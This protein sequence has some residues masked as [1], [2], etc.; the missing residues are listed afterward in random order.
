MQRVAILTKLHSESEW[1]TQK[2]DVGFC[3]MR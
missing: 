3:G 2:I 1:G